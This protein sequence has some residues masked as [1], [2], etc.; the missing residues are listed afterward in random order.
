M[1][2]PLISL[3]SKN[4]IDENIS[5]SLFCAQTMQYSIEYPSHWT[6]NR[7]LGNFMDS[8]VSFH[9]P[10]AEGGVHE[11]IIVSWMQMGDH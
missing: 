3:Y 8:E 5:F 1:T 4:G 7:D 11:M 10:S 9:P 6:I 2:A